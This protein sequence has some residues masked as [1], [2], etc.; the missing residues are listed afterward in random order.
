[1]ENYTK[2]CQNKIMKS[3]SGLKWFSKTTD[4]LVGRHRGFVPWG[5]C[6]HCSWMWL[7][8][9]RGF[10]PVYTGDTLAAC[11]PH[12]TCSPSPSRARDT[13]APG[14]Y[15]D[16]QQS[17]ADRLLFPQMNKFCT[18]CTVVGKSYIHILKTKIKKIIHFIYEPFKKWLLDK[19]SEH[20]FFLKKSVII[21]PPLWILV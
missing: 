21:N 11:R 10:L 2:S 8:G 7:C 16:N 13:S 4:Q 6:K 1:M 19:M 14:S 5:S 20:D 9:W 3:K 15:T 12:S 18:E 17:E